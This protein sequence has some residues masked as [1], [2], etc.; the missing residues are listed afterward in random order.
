[1]SSESVVKCSNCKC[2]FKAQI[3]G[4]CRRD[5]HHLCETCRQ[6]Q[7]LHNEKEEQLYCCIC[8]KKKTTYHKGDFDEWYCADCIRAGKTCSLCGQVFY[9]IGHNPE[10]LKALEDRCCDDCNELVL[11]ARAK[12]R[13]SHCNHHRHHHCKFRFVADV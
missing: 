5:C 6:P 9:G 11:E 2:D 3:S 4:P 1:M 10:P 8:D 12:G 13:L 7:N